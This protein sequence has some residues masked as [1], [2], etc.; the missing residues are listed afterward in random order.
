MYRCDSNIL[1]LLPAADAQM[2]FTLT[3]WNP[4]LP[5]HGW[6]VSA[7]SGLVIGGMTSSYCPSERPANVE[8]PPGNVAALL[9][10]ND[11]E[12]MAMAVQ[13]PGGQAVYLDPDWH[14]KYTVAQAAE[15]PSGSLIGGFAAYRDGGFVNLNGNGMGWVACPPMTSADVGEGG[16]WA[17]AAKNSTNGDSLANCTAVNLKVHPLGAN[18]GPQA[19]EYT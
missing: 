14:M 15:I 6:P 13:V 8:C 17:L 3:A 5:I 19:W 2:P 11:Y 4:F 12:T 9:V 7:N 16:N 10:N 18:A 1:T